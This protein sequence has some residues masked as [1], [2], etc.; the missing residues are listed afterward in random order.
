M[1]S[2]VQ[3][4]RD[5]GCGSIQERRGWDKNTRKS[6]GRRWDVKVYVLFVYVAKGRVK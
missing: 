6:I 5:D 1:V 3:E 4:V 2:P